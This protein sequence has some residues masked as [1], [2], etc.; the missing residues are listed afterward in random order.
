[1]K[2]IIKYFQNANVKGVLCGSNKWLSV[3]NNLLEN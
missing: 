3:K 1:M 2:K